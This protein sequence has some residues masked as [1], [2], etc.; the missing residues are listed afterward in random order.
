MHCYYDQITLP[1]CWRLRAWNKQEWRRTPQ[2]WKGMRHWIE[3]SGYSTHGAHLWIYLAHALATI[4]IINTA[5]SEKGVEGLP[6]NCYSFMMF[7][8]KI[9][10]KTWTLWFFP[11]GPAYLWSATAPIFFVGLFGHLAGPLLQRPW[12]PFSAWL[13][14]FYGCF[15]HNTD[16]EYN[17][18]RMGIGWEYTVCIYIY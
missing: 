13:W 10:E 15:T 18:N 7:N 12:G 5:V 17:G 2:K 8:E 16:F 6:S 1:A 11:M 9:W 3:R 4:S 14:N